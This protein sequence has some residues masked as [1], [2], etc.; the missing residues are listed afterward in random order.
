MC[1]YLR[2][3]FQVSSIILT[4]FRRGRGVGNFTPPLS[5]THTRT[6]ARTHARTHTHTHTEIRVKREITVKFCHIWVSCI[7]FCNRWT[8]LPSRYFLVQSQERKYQN[9]F[10]NLFNVNNK[11]ER[12]IFRRNRSS[13]IR[14]NLV[15][16]RNEIWRWSCKLAV[17]K[18]LSANPTKWSNTLKQFFGY[19][20]RIIWLCLT[21]LWGWVCV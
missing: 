2:T 3:K 6:H 17:I 7:I 12:T 20:R 5:T 1:V 14:L 11:H 19:C 8:I 18:P 10:E 4:S 15:G 9:N 16:I 13:L 21:V